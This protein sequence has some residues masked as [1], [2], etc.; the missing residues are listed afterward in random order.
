MGQYTRYLS[1]TQESAI[2]FAVQITAK[3]PIEML[4]DA[5]RKSAD[6]R[7]SPI[8][9]A[10]L[11]PGEVPSPPS[12]PRS[13]SFFFAPRPYQALGRLKPELFAD[14]RDRVYFTQGLASILTL[15]MDIARSRALLDQIPSSHFEHW[16]LEDGR[17]DVRSVVSEQ[18]MKP[19][20]EIFPITL[21]TTDIPELAVYV[22]QIAAS[23]TT[24]W[25]F[26][27]IHL[28]E[29]RATLIALSKVLEQLILA[30]THSAPTD[31]STTVQ[32][33]NAIVSALVELSA[34]LSYSTTQGSTGA[35]PLLASRSPFPHLSLLGVGGAIRALTKF[36]RYLECAFAQRSAADVIKREFP[37]RRLA[38][39]RIST[40]DSG[41]AY[42]S[43]AHLDSQEDFDL[44]GDFPESST[45]PLLT[46]FSLRHGFKESKFSVTA[47]SESLSA[48]TLPQWTLM[49][50]SHEI[51]HSR[52]RDIFQALFGTTWD[53]HTP[54]E[55]WVGYY[56]DF[57]DWYQANDPNAELPM[58]RAFRNL[59]LNFCCAV[60]RS[61]N[62]VDS[63]RPP[64]D[65]L[66]GSPE[67]LFDYY[68][69]HK[70][71][72]VELFVHFHDYYFAFACQPKLYLM[73]IWA[74][75]T[76]VAAPH[77]RPTEYLIR[78]LATVA[79]G[80][81]LASRAAFDSAA[82][83]LYEALDALEAADIVSPVFDE[84]R[85]RLGNGGE[86]ERAFA[87]F[88]PAYYLTDHVR[89]CFSS[90]VITRCIDK[91]EVDPFAEGS[92]D[93]D[94]YSANVYTFGSADAEEVI[95]PIR[96]CLAALVAELLGRP[97]IGDYQWLTA[98][99]SIVIGS[100]EVRP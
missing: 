88:K 76:K 7:Y 13:I 24:L 28:P 39:Q 62:P 100:Q 85:T 81:G 45:V 10:Y 64:S 31:S 23:V 30:Y 1:A 41:E 91:L 80:S 87:L 36:T 73:S 57:C 11:I 90:R 60:A 68:R 46:Q 4:A 20:V 44:G 25:H 52:V 89:R 17:L 58:D 75:W 55:L 15:D 95:S 49:T 63:R 29:E 16:T 14:E 61:S 26:Y 72:A 82:D 93:V 86:R 98:W 94:D 9:P 42:K 22:E 19:A 8:L 6:V 48:E 12:A 38:V 79:S 32:R 43:K 33:Q 54:F 3:S 21:A 96:F 34:A 99:N 50:L 18:L 70:M 67:D 84:L 5:L 92:P 47:A 37:L 59:V 51:M 97:S 71:L 40:Y 78:T 27:G 74:S 35:S 65:R 53:D 77:L 56:R 66:I 83:Q 2:R 69:R